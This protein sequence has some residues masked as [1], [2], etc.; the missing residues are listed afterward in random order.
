MNG[1]LKLEQVSKGYS[2]SGGNIIIAC[3]DKDMMK[4]FFSGWEWLN[5]GLI[6]SEQLCSLDKGS[7]KQAVVD[8]VKKA[9][10]HVQ[11]DRVVIENIDLLFS[12]EYSLDVIK[13]F[14]QVGK[15]K[16]L[17]ILW[18]GAFKDGVITYAQPGCRDYHRY[19]IKNY[20]AYCITK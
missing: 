15:A 7:R 12:P 2:S 10:D 9:I 17:I 11:S 13:L 18:E 6:V 20:D 3:V 8:I 19:E 1:Y 16:N 14:A 4:T 5:L